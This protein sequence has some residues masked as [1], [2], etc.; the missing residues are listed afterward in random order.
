[1]TVPSL[2]FRHFL[3]HGIATRVLWGDVYLKCSA[4]YIHVHSG[5]FTK[6][7]ATYIGFNHPRSV[8]RS[9]PKRWA[10]AFATLLASI[11]WRETL[12]MR[13]KKLLPLD[14]NSDLLHW[15]VALHFKSL[16]FLFSLE[17]GLLRADFDRRLKA[18][19][20]LSEE[21][22]P[23]QASGAKG[24]ES[25]P[26]KPEVSQGLDEGEGEEEEPLADD[27][28][29]DIVEDEEQ[30][31]QPEESQH[32]AEDVS[33]AVK[34]WRHVENM[35]FSVVV[36]GSLVKHAI[37]P[38]AWSFFAVAAEAAAKLLCKVCVIKKG[39]RFPPTQWW[40][41]PRWPQMS[42]YHFCLLA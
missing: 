7:H 37:W 31:D 30:P 5:C 26:S 23:D 11:C 6:K 1:M 41:I 38:S 20:T 27:P 19:G 24:T 32:G 25:Q 17:A 21:A 39:L 22:S 4:Y 18:A 15:F 42:L 28:P 3:E 12:W 40:N 8:A 16:G 13:S 9:T 14:C 33:W 34:V 36:L 35:W 29:A 10:K 2:L